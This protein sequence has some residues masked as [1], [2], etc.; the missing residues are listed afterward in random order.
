MITIAGAM[1]GDF[2]ANAPCTANLVCTVR[3]LEGNRVGNLVL[4]PTSDSAMENSER[5]T[6][7][8]VDSSNYN[9]AANNNVAFDITDPTTPGSDDDDEMMRMPVALPTLAELAAI[10]TTPTALVA[11]TIGNM[12]STSIDG[13]AITGFRYDDASNMPQVYVQLLIHAHLGIWTNGQ[14][15]TVITSPT[16]MASDFDHDFRYAFLGDNAVTSRPNSGTAGYGIAGNATYKGVNFFPRGTLFTDFAANT[17]T[18]DL[19]ANGRTLFMA[20]RF[21]FGSAT[22]MVPDGVG[23]Q[24]AVRSADNLRIT[25]SGTITANGFTSTPTIDFA[26]G[27][28]SD[29]QSIDSATFSGRFYDAAG[30]NPATADPAEIAGAGV[31]VD[32]GG[33]N[34]LHFGFI[35]RCSSNC[36]AGD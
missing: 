22:A 13:V 9:F 8:L 19:Q 35:G 29:L 16:A 27:F 20:R 14:V 25:L 12:Q 24:R 26:F 23:G 7:S 1:D 4:M 30:Y 32:G 2:T 17:Y 11:S 10:D 6:A 5:W 15:P 3:I 21:S 28:F 33:M 18:S 34:D 36:A 31:I